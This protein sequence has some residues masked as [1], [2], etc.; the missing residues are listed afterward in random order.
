M[1]PPRLTALVVV[2]V[3]LI[4]FV[5]AQTDGTDPA[6]GATGVQKERIISKEISS[7]LSSGIKYQSPAP[8]ESTAEDTGSRD[9]DK[10]QNGIIRLPKY[11]VEEQ[12]PPVF[13]ERNL[14]TPER[15]R[16][17]AYLRY[18]NAFSRRLRLVP[19]WYAVMQYE[20]EER[21][22]NLAEME[23]RVWMY[24]ISGDKA[25]AEALKTDIQRTFMRRSEG[26]SIHVAGD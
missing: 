16:R 9:S 15:L 10:P 2:L 17:L 20:A 14:Y 5:A 23:D 13:N 1:K 18:T 21:K 6:P 12:R 26:I 24:R 11:V 8:L 7:A 22:R 19:E 3:P 4:T 25:S